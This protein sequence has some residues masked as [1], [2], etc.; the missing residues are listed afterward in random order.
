M[1]TDIKQ[2]RKDCQRILQL[3]TQIAA[4]KKEKKEI[5]NRLIEDLKATNT[6]TAYLGEFNGKKSYL[7][8]RKGF[9]YRPL[10]KNLL[11]DLVEKWQVDQDVDDFDVQDLVKYIWERRSFYEYSCLTRH[12]T[13]LGAKRKVTSDLESLEMS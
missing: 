5:Q 11:T 10:Q 12:S 8:S 1:T 2:M 7:T 9:V 13:V 6:K 3:E 4:M